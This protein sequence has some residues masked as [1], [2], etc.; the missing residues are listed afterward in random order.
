MWLSDYNKKPKKDKGDLRS[1]LEAKVT[2]KNLDDEMIDVSQRDD[3]HGD[4]IHV[5][6]TIL[7]DLGHYDASD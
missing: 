7:D 6:D 3:I 2:A 5:V 1:Y 4:E